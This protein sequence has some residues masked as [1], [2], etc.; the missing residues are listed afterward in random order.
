M[1]RGLEDSSLASQCGFYRPE[2][3]SK[4]GDPMD[5]NFEDLK[6][7]KW[8]ITTDRT[9]RVDKKNGIIC[10]VIMFTPEVIVNKM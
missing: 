8:N 6:M 5:L 3:N 10:L 1:L 4:R 7:Q 9:Q 2:H